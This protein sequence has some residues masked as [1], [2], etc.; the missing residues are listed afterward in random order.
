MSHSK[1]PPQ[2]PIKGCR[3]ADTFFLALQIILSLV[4][5]RY[6][7]FFCFSQWAF[8]EPKPFCRMLYPCKA[9]SPC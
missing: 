2:L 8:G 9:N 5:R 3:F 1:R 6:R 4:W 7:P